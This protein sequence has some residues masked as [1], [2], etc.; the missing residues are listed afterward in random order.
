M[1][2]RV[3]KL[4]GL[5]PIAVLDDGGDELINAVRMACA[6]IVQDDERKSA[7]ESRARSSAGRRPRR[8]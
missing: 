2:A 6:V 5:D 8:R 7:E 3:A 4:F 1:A